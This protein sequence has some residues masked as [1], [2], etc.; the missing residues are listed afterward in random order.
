[1]EKLRKETLIVFEW[2]NEGGTEIPEEHLEEL[3]ESGDSQVSE[4]I[5]DGYTSGEL[6]DTVYDGEQEFKYIGTWSITTKV[7]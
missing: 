2:R 6:T 4:K 5:G 3:E 1:M 7:V